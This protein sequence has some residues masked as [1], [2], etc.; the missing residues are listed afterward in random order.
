MKK[1][2][3]DSVQ[4]RVL[5]HFTNAD[6]LG[7]YNQEFMKKTLKFKFLKPRAVC[8]FQQIKNQLRTKFDSKEFRVSDW[9]R[10]WPLYC[11]L[12]VH[13]NTNTTFRKPKPLYINSI[14]QE[15]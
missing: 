3:Q 2:C 10:C 13:L 15:Y 7:I 8:P 9:K 5:K 12:K 14:L 6:C 11:C 4:I 1:Q